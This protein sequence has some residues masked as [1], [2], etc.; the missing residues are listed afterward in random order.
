MGF[1]SLQHLKA[2]RSACH[3]LLPARHV[4]PSGF[5]YPLDGLLPS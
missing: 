5:G 3:G 2:R 4:P 1:S